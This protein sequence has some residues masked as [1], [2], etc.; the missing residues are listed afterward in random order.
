MHTATTYCYNYQSKIPSEI[1]EPHV[2]HV[3]DT[4][5]DQYNKN[6]ILR[7][8]VMYIQKANML[9]NGLVGSM[10]ANDIAEHTMSHESTFTHK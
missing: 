5:T 8:R 6:S 9:K 1:D 3:R 2:L 10:I 4:R 7:N